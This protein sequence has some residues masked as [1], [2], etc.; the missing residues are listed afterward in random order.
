M[1]RE[2][3]TLQLV[4]NEEKLELG[5]KYQKDIAQEYRVSVMTLNRWLKKHNISVARGYVST[6]KQLEIYSALGWPDRYL[7]LSA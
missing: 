4:V 2:I 7:R 1:D 3:R 5:L 6:I